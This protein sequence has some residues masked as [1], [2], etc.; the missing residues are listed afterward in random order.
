M[1]KQVDAMLVFWAEQAAGGGERLGAGGIDISTMAVAK[2]GVA[3][4]AEPTARGVQSRVAK[5]SRVSLS[6]LAL[7][8]D[9]AVA[10]LPDA[11]KACVKGYYL[12]GGGVYCER[13]R[14][15]GVCRSTVYRRL[16]KAH[17]AL[18]ARLGVVVSMA[19]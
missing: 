7:D 6:E 9:R 14:R 19:S 13:L 4:V 18:A 5:K 15:Q 11:L 3:A 12:E 2:A 1:I 8:V 17:E 10:A 16:H